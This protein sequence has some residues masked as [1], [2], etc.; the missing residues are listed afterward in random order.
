MKALFLWVMPS[1]VE[2]GVLAKHRERQRAMRW[3]KATRLTA[4][5]S[6]PHIEGLLS[7]ICASRCA[8]FALRIVS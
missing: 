2:R 1:P 4:C 8:S 7:L 6:D 5:A 3:L